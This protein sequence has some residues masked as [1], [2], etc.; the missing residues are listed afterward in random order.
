MYDRPV[1][2][3]L[4]SIEDWILQCLYNHP[5]DKHSTLSLLEQLDQVLTD[6]PSEFE[7]CN[8]IRGIMGATPFSVDEY[9]AQ[10][11]PAR[12]AVQQAVETL[13][14]EG[15]ASGKR[16]SDKEG[17]FFES[18]DLTNKGRRETLARTNDKVKR[19][20]PPRSFEGTVR[21]IRER[22]RNE[23]KDGES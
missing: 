11:K 17:V 14:R 7:E 16:N 20:T 8:R 10:R 5:N 18:L 1:P 23:A 3:G 4:G 19:E 12:D 6:E 13:I 2:A 22:K 15:W 21:E 9:E